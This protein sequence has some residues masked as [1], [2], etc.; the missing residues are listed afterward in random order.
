M[1]DIGNLWDVVAV[2]CSD[3]HSTAVSRVVAAHRLSVLR[4]NMESTTNQW[5]LGTTSSDDI[6]A[7]AAGKERHERLFTNQHDPAERI[8]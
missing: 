6:K 5:P 8:Q 2:R 3:F 4:A 1:Q 7:T